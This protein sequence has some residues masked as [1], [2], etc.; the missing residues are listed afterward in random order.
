[1]PRRK[2]FFID[3]P[4]TARERHVLAL[5]LQG[6]SLR[7]IA[8]LMHTTKGCINSTLTMCRQKLGCDN[9]EQLRAYARLNGLDVVQEVAS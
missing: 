1:M 5:D 7:G 3:I 2:R 9:R 6:L 8:E 4:L